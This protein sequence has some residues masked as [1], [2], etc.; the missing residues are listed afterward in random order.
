[1]TPRKQQSTSRLQP[2]PAVAW[3]IRVAM[4]LLFV[5]LLLACAAAWVVPIEV[6]QQ[7][8]LDRAGTGEFAKFEAIGEAEFSVWLV[9]IVSLSLLIVGSILWRDLARW[10]AFVNAAWTGLM[11]VTR[12]DDDGAAQAHTSMMQRL[13]TVG[14]RA[15]LCS[16]AVLFV[17]HTVHAIGLRIHD[18]PYF[19]FNSGEVVLP[20]M[21]VS[22][23]AVIRYLQQT[24]PP[25]AR[26]LVASDQKLFF[27]S[28]YLRPRT[29]LHQ[30]H[31]GSEHVIPLKDQERK[32]EAYRLSD[33]S[34][35]DLSR[36]NHD[37][38]LEYF[39]HPSMVDAKQVLDDSAWIA[40]IRGREQNPNLIPNYLV[41][42][43][44]A[45]AH[46]P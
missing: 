45:G 13:R 5:G 1:M 16:W 21:S 31:P 19:R 37:F 42:L 4:V 34:A 33:L 26:I 46:Q 40:F 41:R 39:E 32:L 11:Q 28:Y 15:F 6:F 17:A 9:R 3:P 8:A 24:T 14:I 38:T 25:H 23:K 44:P 20:N 29:L 18:W 43:R 12:T 2:T 7:W 27:L 22:N 36:M 30:M 35:E 10:V